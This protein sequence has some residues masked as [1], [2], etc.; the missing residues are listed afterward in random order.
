MASGGVSPLLNL[1][2]TVGLGFNRGLT[3]PLAFY[4]AEG[5]TERNPRRGSS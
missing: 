1:T 4:H 5:D 2:A 3:P